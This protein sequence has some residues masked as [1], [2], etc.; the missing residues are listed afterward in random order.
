MRTEY[1]HK[2]N[3][4]KKLRSAVNWWL[5]DY[6]Y[7]GV[8]KLC[9]IFFHGNV[10]KWGLTWEA[11]AGEEVRIPIVILLTSSDRD[12]KVVPL[13]TKGQDVLEIGRATNSEDHVLVI[14]KEF[15]A[16]TQTH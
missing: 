1:T 12:S 10:Y 14:I 9:A 6:D 11:P 5:K 7:T 4:S 15:I 3:L 8:H 2:D 16:P 13:P